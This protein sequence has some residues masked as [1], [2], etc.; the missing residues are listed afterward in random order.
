MLFTGEC[1]VSD[2]LTTPILN[3]T[4]NATIGGN[5]TVNGKVTSNGSN[6]ITHYCPI[7]AGEEIS[8]YKIGKPVFMSGH[9][10][11]RV[12]D[13]QDENINPIWQSSTINDST[14]CICSVIVD[15]SWKDFVGIITD[16]DSENGCIKFATHGDYLF[17][18]DDANLYQ[19]GD[20]LLYDGRILDEDYAMTLKIQQSIVGKVS[21]KINEHY[22]ALFKA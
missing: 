2:K 13:T 19:I 14:D 3:A 15:G 5:L 18:V 8:Y 12:I 17:Y 4:G 9:V 16:V 1:I 22:L 7:E 21:G 20:V 10:Y 6:T 11:K